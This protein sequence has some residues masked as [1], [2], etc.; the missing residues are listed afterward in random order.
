MNDTRII[1]AG[2]AAVCCVGLLSGCGEEPIPD[3][4]QEENLPY[5]ATMRSDKNSFGVPMTYDRRFLEEEQVAV[6]ADLLASVQNQDTAL[7]EQT[8]PD[9]YVRYQRDEVYKLESTEALLGVIHDR[10]AEASG[11]DFQFSMVLITD[12]SQDQDSGNLADALVLFNSI[13]DGDGKFSDTL[14]EAW[15]LTVEWDFTY[16]NGTQYSVSEGEHMYLF[17]TTN[18]YMVSF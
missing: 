6:V 13:Y 11:E 16:D 18:G 9:F 8:A 17:H 15:E 12:I 3:F 2:L 14:E 10:L 4:T 7:F 5:G 1:A